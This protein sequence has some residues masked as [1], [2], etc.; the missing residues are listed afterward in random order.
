MPTEESAQLALRTQQIIGH[1]TGI[2]DV[3]DP[4]AGSV[5]I[6]ELTDKIELEANKIINN[7]DMLG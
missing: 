1:E 2:P 4:L 6:E 7:I 5:Y 3:A